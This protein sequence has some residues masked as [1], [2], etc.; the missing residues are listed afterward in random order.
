MAFNPAGSLR[1]NR[2]LFIVVF[3]ACAAVFVGSLLMQRKALAKETAQAA[4]HARAV[5]NEVDGLLGVKQLEDPI[6]AKTADELDTRLGH[7][8]AGGSVMAVRVW[9]PGGDLRYSSLPKDQSAPI[10]ETL[11]ASTKGVGRIASFVDAEVLTTY[12]PLRTGPDGAPFGA[13]EV[14][15]SYTPVL[16]AAATPWEAVRGGSALLGA[17]M[18]VFIVIGSFAA[19]PARR[20]AKEG[21]GFVGTRDPNA[22]PTL[23]VEEFQR[24]QE[25][26]GESE[27]AQRALE[28]ELE[29]VNARLA[30]DNERATT[31]V[32][33][34]Q[35]E[36]GRVQTKLQEVQV[37]AT[38][39]QAPTA[40]DEELAGWKTR[41]EASEKKAVEAEHRAQMAE[42]RIGELTNQVRSLEEQ[43]DRA[44]QTEPGTAQTGVDPEVERLESEQAELRSEN[45]RL[46]SEKTQL[47]VE[48]ARIETQAGQLASEHARQS[49]EL[50]FALE[51]AREAEDLAASLNDQLFA[52]TERTDQLLAATERS[53]A[54]ADTPA[55]PADPNAHL[56]AVV[57]SAQATTENDDDAGSL[58]SRLARAADRK[59][60]P[61][62]DESEWPD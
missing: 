2:G 7:A 4:A 39:R 59:R 26:L 19:L 31:R 16:E 20:A 49:D 35:D 43:L 14:Q 34:L 51:R 28:G 60:R 22:V 13:V 21:A 50:Q 9:T 61:V 24:M 18:F 44:A 42:M 27:A 10:Q 33:Q 23:S 53:A 12:V 6:D 32:T 41:A 54:P 46:E 25:E 11:S 40:D 8:T 62:K 36:L 55:G 29:R 15:A 1:R 38:A 30:A 37:A 5:A 57:A 17:L 56:D 47:E 52:A 48:R 45:A 3:L 58:R